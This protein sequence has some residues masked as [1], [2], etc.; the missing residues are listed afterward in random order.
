MQQ[1]LLTRRVSQIFL[2]VVLLPVLVPIYDK[3]GL[4]TY[5]IAGALYWLLIG[6][7]A[8]SV[9]GLKSGIAGRQGLLASAAMLIASW[10]VISLALNMD[11]PPQGEAWLA[12]RIDQQIRYIFIVT[13]GLLAF[14]GLAV[15]TSH[16]RRTEQGVLPVLAFAAA[17]ISTVLFTLLFVAYPVCATWRFEQE[18]R[19]G[20]TL[21]WWPLFTALFS[22]IQTLEKLLFFVAVTMYAIA[23]RNSGLIGKIGVACLIGL[24]LLLATVNTMVHVPPAAPF[25]LPYL[26]GLILLRRPASAHPALMGSQSLS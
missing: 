26:I 1:N 3:G 9:G 16:L 17:V 2:W 24:T 10:A 5:L 14:G 4:K 18:A 25:I 20:A 12:T 13:G 22:S 8:W 21:G 15:L 19:L 6:A 11:T 7:A 23:L